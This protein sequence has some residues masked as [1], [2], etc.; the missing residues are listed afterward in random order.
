MRPVCVQMKKALSK[1][2]GKKG[3][4]AEEAE[5]GLTEEQR[6]QAKKL[7]EEVGSILCVCACVW[8]SLSLILTRSS[9]LDLSICLSFFSI[10]RRQ[11]SAEHK[12]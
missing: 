2:K 1:K 12:K 4:E 5:A 9:F 3:E 11:F 10:L 7:K 8:L 6:E